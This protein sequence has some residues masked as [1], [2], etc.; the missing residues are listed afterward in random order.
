[1]SKRGALIASACALAAVAVGAWVFLAPRG[2]PASELAAPHQADLANGE[3]VFIAANCT[4][5]HATPDQDDRLQLAGGLKLSS[6]FGDFVAPNISPDPRYGIGAWTEAEFVNALKRGVGRNGQHLYPSLPYPAY[7]KMTT[8]DV[9]DLFAY[10]KT[11]PAVAKPT[12]PHD[13]RF[14]YTLRIGV[15]VWK[16]LYFRPE[17][18]KPDPGQSAAWNRGAYLAEGA[19][20]CAECH[21]PRDRLGGPIED[22][23]YAGAPS[24]EAGGRFANNIT[25]HAD[26]IGD[27]SEEDIASFLQTGQD[28]CFNEP[29]GMAAVLAST[30]RMSEEDV[31]ALATY[32]RSL[33]PI[34]GGAEHKTC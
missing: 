19:T 25:S 24:L 8:A 1:M 32:I 9:R 13:L 21:T 11:L 4:G 15:G 2:M 23:R 30:T 6:S 28:R 34:P 17:E 27:W 20:H 31:N 18:F 10:L 26:G 22:K 16:A 7:S 33:P 3:A 5:C 14:P 29:A 12:A